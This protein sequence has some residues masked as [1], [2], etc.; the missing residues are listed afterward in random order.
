[1]ERVLAHLAPWLATADGITI[2][3]GEPFEQPAALLAMLKA[4]R[5]GTR[6]DILVYSGL[7]VEQLV[8]VLQQATGLIDALISDPFEIGARHSK[9]LRG[10]DNQRLHL[11]TA[12]G[13]ER[14]G[15]YECAGAQ[16]DKALDVMFDHDGSV[17]FA[18]IPARGDFLRLQE[19]LINQGHRVQISADKAHNSKV[20]PL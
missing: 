15:V 1:M 2:S 3:G 4:L 8:S 12:L 19:I 6:A 17:W 18:G 9:P 5:S 13:R 20:Q 14:F 16:P 7:P 11:L 10:S